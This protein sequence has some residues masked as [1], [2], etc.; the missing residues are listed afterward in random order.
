MKRV[1]AFGEVLL[2]LLPPEH[3]RVEQAHFFT[4]RAGGPE[5]SVTAALVRVG[6]PASLVT[7]LPDTPVGRLVAADIRRDGVGDKYILMRDEG[8]VGIAFVEV[9]TGIRQ[10]RIFSDREGTAFGRLKEREVPWEKIF[11][12]SDHF[13]ISEVTPTLGK[14]CLEMTKDGLA[15]AK[16]LGLTTSLSVTGQGRTVSDVL[17]LE[18]VTPLMEKIDHLI[19][20]DREASRVF[21][22]KNED[23]EA[24]A[25]ELVGRFNLE[26]CAVIVSHDDPSGKVRFFSLAAAGKGLLTDKTY[27]TAVIDRAGVAEAFAAGYILGI[28]SGDIGAGLK[29]ANAMAALAYTIPGDI[30]S[31]GQEELAE[32][33]GVRNILTRPRR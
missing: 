22:M 20:T 7:A 26:S 28:L 13:H 10:S 18:T 25:R 21:R 32:F 9:G 31:C 5:L 1:A 14:S 29:A 6:V 3:E 16:N 11:P 17:V 12:E 33:S 4:A 2:T 15:R 23:H 27:E 19:T 30:L 8:R 24:S